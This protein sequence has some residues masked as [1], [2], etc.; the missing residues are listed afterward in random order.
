MGHRG[1]QFGS[2]QTK[3]VPKDVVRSLLAM[4]NK[5]DNDVCAK[6]CMPCHLGLFMASTGLTVLTKCTKE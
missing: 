4:G 3:S 5:N 6:F 2:P 1:G